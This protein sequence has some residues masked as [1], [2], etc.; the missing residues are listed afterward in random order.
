MRELPTEDLSCTYGA[1]VM[2]ALAVEL[3]REHGTACSVFEMIV[4][5]LPA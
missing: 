4:G 1:V 3:D 2:A 5:I